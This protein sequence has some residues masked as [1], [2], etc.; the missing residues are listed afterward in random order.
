MICGWLNPSLL[1]EVRSTQ[2]GLTTPI[3]IC[4]QHRRT[5]FT[6]MHYRVR[7]CGQG[8]AA[9]MGEK[10]TVLPHGAHSKQSCSLSNWLLE[11]PDLVKGAPTDWL[12]VLSAAREPCQPLFWVMSQ[13]RWLT[14]RMATETA[15]PSDVNVKPAACW[16]SPPAPG[17]I[18]TKKNDDPQVGTLGQS[19]CLS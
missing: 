10:W 11:V 3:G 14:P 1:R 7:T 6:L 17:D 13:F 15:R 5:T 9:P 19:R 8:T 18:G 4:G 12:A 2:Q 16:V